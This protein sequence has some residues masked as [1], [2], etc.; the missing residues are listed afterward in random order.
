MWAYK[1]TTTVTSSQ[2]LECPDTDVGKPKYEKG[3]GPS[4]TPTTWSYKTFNDA[5]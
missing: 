5:L 3:Q 4:S 2:P 1:V